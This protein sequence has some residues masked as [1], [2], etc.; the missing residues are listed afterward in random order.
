MNLPAEILKRLLHGASSFRAGTIV[1]VSRPVQGLY[2]VDRGMLSTSVS[3]PLRPGD[4]VEYRGPHLGKEEVVL[5]PKETADEFLARVP[6]DQE[7][8]WITRD[9]FFVYLPKGVVSELNDR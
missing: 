4:R 1:T 7:R 8:T 5:I 6:K 3:I 2:L 9:A